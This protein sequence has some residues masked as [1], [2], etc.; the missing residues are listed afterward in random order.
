M[1]FWKKQALKLS[2]RNGKS[3]RVPLTPGLKGE[4]V[5]HTHKSG[6]IFGQVKDAGHRGRKQSASR[7]VD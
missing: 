1:N 2:S 5:K 3:R 6:Y 7:S 4:L